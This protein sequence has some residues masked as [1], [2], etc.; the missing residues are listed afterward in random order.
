[1]MR[2]SFIVV[3]ALV[4]AAGC[5]GIIKAAR[6]P[7]TGQFPMPDLRVS[8]ARRPAFAPRPGRRRCSSWPPT[9]HPRRDLRLVIRLPA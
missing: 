6:P 4:A 3:A 8:P 2:K 9:T 5:A 7:R 1:M